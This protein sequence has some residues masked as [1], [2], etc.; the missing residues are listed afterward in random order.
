MKITC[1]ETE[2]PWISI[3]DFYT[4]YELDFIWEELNFLSYSDRLESP[5]ETNSARINNRITK[6]NKGVFL[7]DLYRERKYS[8]ILTCT[9]KLL[10]SSNDDKFLEVLKN[11]PSWFYKNF[12]CIK[13][14]TLLSY[15]EN[16][17]YYEA[18]RDTSNITALTWLFKEP[19][20]FTGGDLIFPDTQ[21][22]IECKNNKVILF[23]GCATHQVTQINMEKQHQNNKLGRWCISQF[24]YSNPSVTE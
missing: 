12:R 15:Y 24:L 6:K 20:R 9:R 7:D 22:K 11:H 5:E 3:E 4:Q 16:N 8:N 19:K 14:F 13:D 1:H 10:H 23:P 2:H 21:E 17:D 18:H